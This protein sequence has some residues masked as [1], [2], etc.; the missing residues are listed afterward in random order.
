MLPPNQNRGSGSSEPW[1][2]EITSAEYS[3]RNRQIYTVY[4]SLLSLT[5][6]SGLAVV[7]GVLRFDV[8]IIITGLLLNVSFTR[9]TSAILYAGIVTGYDNGQTFDPLA[10]GSGILL[11]AQESSGL[12]AVTKTIAVSF[13]PPF[14]PIIAAKN[15]VGPYVF[16]NTGVGD[17]IRGHI[18]V[19]YT[20]LVL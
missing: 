1:S 4:T 2:R 3:A 13:E 5:G 16:N 20:N 14:M 10:R 9:A 8:D 19:Y 15:T 11:H 6:G 12:A 17:N 18:V 7:Q